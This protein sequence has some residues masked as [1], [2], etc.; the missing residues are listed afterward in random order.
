MPSIEVR[1]NTKTLGDTPGSISHGY[2]WVP[3][4]LT[5]LKVLNS[6]LKF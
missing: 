6:N 2:S 3:P 1:Q 4:G 5:R